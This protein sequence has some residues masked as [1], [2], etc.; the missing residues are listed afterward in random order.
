MANQ[1]E[2]M[3]MQPPAWMLEAARNAVKVSGVN[4]EE[5]FAARICN[6]RKQAEAGSMQHQETMSLLAKKMKELSPKSVL[7]SFDSFEQANV[8]EEASGTERQLAETSAAPIVATSRKITQAPDKNKRKEVVKTPDKKHSK[9]ARIL[10]EQVEKGP[11][12]KGTAR[13]PQKAALTTAVHNP[14]PKETIPAPSKSLPISKYKVEEYTVLENLPEWYTSISPDNIHMKNL[15]KR[16]PPALTALDALKGLA[17]QCGD[18]PNKYRS[19]DLPNLYNKLRDLIHQAEI[20][21]PVTPYILRK[22]QMLSSQAGLPC[23]F[24]AEANFPPDIKA[25]S[26]QLYKRWYA[27]NLTQDLLRGIITKKST[28]RSSDSICPIYRAKYPITSKYIGQGDLVPGQWWPTQLCAV[29]DSAH[30]HT[31]GGIFGSK[32]HGAYS[33]V[34]ANGSGYSDLDAGD[35]IHYSGTENNDH[36]GSVTENTK[37]LLTS[38]QTRDP[39]RVLRSAQLAKGNKYRPERGIRYDGLYTVVGYEVLDEKKGVLRFRLERCEGQEGIRWEGEARRPTVYEVREYER[40]K[41]EGAWAGGVE[42]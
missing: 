28:N 25:D 5:A 8:G 39:V 2:E 15:S 6:V 23:I 32:T 4:S 21:L 29:R 22:A 42:K 16:R 17:R 27:G 38:L 7:R 10:T 12:L 34:L 9:K 13:Q 11:S 14:N 33:I 1:S 3:S 40:L 37:H 35:T 19:S 26:Y 30:G 31:Q 24:R 36:A 20:T 18:A 41:E